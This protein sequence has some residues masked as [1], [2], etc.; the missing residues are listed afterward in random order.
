MNDA[1]QDKA[2]RRIGWSDEL[3]SAAHNLD[4]AQFET[5]FREHIRGYRLSI[6]PDELDYAALQNFARTG[7]TPSDVTDTDSVNLPCP[8]HGLTPHHL[9]VR[10]G[11]TPHRECTAC[12][13]DS[14]NPVPP[15]AG[16]LTPAE[17]KHVEYYNG[18]G[19][20]V[21]WF[22]GRRRKNG[23][24]E[25]LGVGVPDSEGEG[26]FV[27]S[28]LINGETCT[29]SEASLGPFETGLNI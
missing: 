28:L 7:L 20:L 29:T 9:V 16:E 12:G 11:F 17:R 5:F 14:A 22:V 1:E 3:T 15:L 24:I 19:V 23:D 4:L 10:T 21:D 2:Y 6:D 13:T 18:Y 26:S 8:I 25:V 27:W